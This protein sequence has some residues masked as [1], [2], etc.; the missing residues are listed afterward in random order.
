MALSWRV[1]VAAA[2]IVLSAAACSSAPSPGRATAPAML[3][4]AGAPGT[5]RA[6]LDRTVGEMRARLQRNPKDT[7]AACRLADALLRL[8]RVTGRG[9]LSVQAEQALALALQADPAA[10]DAKRMLAAV[11]LS[12]H[13]FRDAIVQANRALQDRTNDAWLYGVLGDGHLELGEYDAAFEAFDRMNAI[14]PNAAAYGRASYARELQGDRDGAL[15]LM[16]MAAEA[17]PASD[18]E[19][20]A[21]HH[22]QIG[23]LL[24]DAGHLTEARRQFAYADHLFPG[25]PLALDGLARATAAS[26]D[27]AKALE[28]VRQRLES[29]PT[30]DDYAL[31]GDLMQALGDGPGAERQY[32]L[33]EATW[34]ADMPEPSRLARFLAVHHRDPDATV[35]LAT[36]VWAV[37]KDIFTADA[38]AWAHFQLGHVAEAQTFIRQALRTGS[39]DRTIRYH[40]AAIAA[41]AGA[42]G[43]ARRLVREALD[44]L[45]HFDLVSASAASRLSVSLRTGVTE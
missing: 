1:M 30:P 12:E 37:R 43:D 8:A 9:T 29:A 41:R 32:R 27:F 6:A 4:A 15:R 44:G 35:R 14:K 11:Y 31:A 3:G 42:T 33:A 24:L 5:D 13:R 34:R 25:H 22:S 17:T 2:G 45:P 16:R 20:Q 39:R 38:L 23:F 18:P 7:A 28:L 26:G 36:N 19:S 21:W 10:Y 40:A